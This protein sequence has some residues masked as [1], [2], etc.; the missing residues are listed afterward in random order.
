MVSIHL[1]AWRTESPGTETSMYESFY[2]YV[3]KISLFTLTR[4]LLVTPVISKSRLGGR[5][6]LQLVGSSAVEPA[7]SMGQRG[8]HSLHLLSPLLSTLP[9][10]SP[11]LLFKRRG[12]RLERGGGSIG[13]ASLI[14]SPH[15]PSHLFSLTVFSSPPFSSPYPKKEKKMQEIHWKYR[16]QSLLKNVIFL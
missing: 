14:S 3:Q 5:G 13:S 1:F 16:I 15:L 2:C 10:P 7:L 8:R 11:L 9:I 4:N 6:Y 12:G